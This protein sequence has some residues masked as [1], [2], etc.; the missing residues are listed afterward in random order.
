MEFGSEADD[1]F[2]SDPGEAVTHLWVDAFQ[3]GVY[4]VGVLMLEEDLIQSLEAKC[5]DLALPCM[6]VL[7]PILRLFQS[8]LGA[9]T[10]LRAGA[11][12]VLN[13]D[14]FQRIVA[15]NFT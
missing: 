3:D 1:D 7:G 15:L 2:W 6:S 14:Y 10:M 11:Q 12:H 4:E 9:E 13:A 8:Y 5:R